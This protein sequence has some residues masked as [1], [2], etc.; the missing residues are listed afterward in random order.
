MADKW[1]K[2]PLSGHIRDS[3]VNMESVACI[4]PVEGKA[5]LRILHRSHNAVPI[6]ISYS[7]VA[8]R[9]ADFDIIK[10]KLSML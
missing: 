6:E 5:V 8:V 9:D 10:S 4:T 3:L 1:I 7:N 2:R